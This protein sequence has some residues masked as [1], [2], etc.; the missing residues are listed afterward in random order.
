MKIKKTK[1]KD[2][3]I[4][5]NQ[6]Y[7]DSRGEFRELLIEKEIKIK[8]PFNVISISKKNVIRG[9]HY[10]VNKPQGKFISVLK[11][12]ILDV[13]VD[14]RKNSKTFGKH[15]KIL[16]SEKNCKSIFIPGGFAHG[17]SCLKKHNI[18]IYSCTNYRNPAGEKGILWN[19][20]S[21]KI[22][23]KVKNPIVSKKDQNNPKFK[24]C[25]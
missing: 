4:V 14:L 8:F 17:F 13:A 2:L 18:V 5:E 12:E 1:F 23:W 3:L 16:L 10:Q 20:K 19:D 6:K 22:N 7:L 15:Y 9:L 24:D 11:G 25:F 21:L